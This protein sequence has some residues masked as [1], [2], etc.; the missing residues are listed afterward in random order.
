MKYNEKFHAERLLKMLE[1][2]NLCLSCPTLKG[3]IGSETL[4]CAKENGVVSQE[5]CI[6]CRGFINLTGSNC[7]CRAL[8]SKEAAKRTWLA[9]ERKGYLK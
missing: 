9:L 5:T 7:P 4:E 2:R 3:F 1:R 8:G 6:I